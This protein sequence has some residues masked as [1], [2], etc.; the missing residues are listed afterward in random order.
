MKR[1][2]N[3]GFS[4]IPSRLAHRARPIRQ[5]WTDTTLSRLLPPS[6]AT[7]GSGYLQLHPTATT[8]R[9][10]R[11]FTPIRNTRASWRTISFCSFRTCGQS[12]S[13]AAVKIRCRSRRT[14][15]SW[16]RQSMASQSRAAS[17][18]PF[19]VRAPSSPRGEAYPS[20][21]LTCPSVPAVPASSSKAHLP[22]WAPFRARAPGPVSG[23][24]YETTK[25]RVRSPL[26]GFLSPFGRRHSLLGHP[27][28]P[29]NFRLPYGRPTH[30]WSARDPDGVSMFRTREIRLGSGA[31]FTPGRWCS[32]G[33]HR[34]P[35]TRRISADMVL[36]F[37][38]PSPELSVTRLT[39]VHVR[40][41]FR[42]SPCL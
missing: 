14:L 33:R 6:P 10:R 18:G 20:W 15:S 11:S 2:N 40:S 27:V 5:Y 31:S 16:C 37:G 1:R 13:C 41:P 23:Q 38:L 22:M 32:R 34:N 42:P 8:M 19:T 26:L 3:T 17:S 39:E 28:P 30:G 4:R 7:P 9:R 24:L 12:P 21:R 25:R 36:F 35:A 29:R